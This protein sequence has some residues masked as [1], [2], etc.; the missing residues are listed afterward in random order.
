[1]EAR[2]KPGFGRFR[3]SKLRDSNGIAAR[4]LVQAIEFAA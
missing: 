1:M 4:A 2:A 3:A